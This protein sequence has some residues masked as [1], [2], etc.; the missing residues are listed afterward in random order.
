MVAVMLAETS[1]DDLESPP[2]S[3]PASFCLC[4]AAMSC[5]PSLT[6]LRHLRVDICSL[7]CAPVS[8]VTY[9][10]FVDRGSVV[11]RRCLNARDRQTVDAGDI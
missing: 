5:V 4:V 11:G 6:T 7:D 3:V 1:F 8:S 9:P 2:L 10:L